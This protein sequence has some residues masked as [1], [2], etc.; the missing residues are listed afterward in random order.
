MPPT[1]TDTHAEPAEVEVVGPPTTVPRT[2]SRRP[3]TRGRRAERRPRTRP[4]RRTR[5]V[6]DDDV[7]GRRTSTTSCPAAG[8]R[9]ASR[10]PDGR[11]TTR[12]STATRSTP[13]T[14]ATPFR[15]DAALTPLIVA[16]GASSS[17]SWPT[18]RTRCSTRCAA[19]SRSATSMPSC[20]H[21]DHAARY[22]AA[23]EA[24]LVDAAGPE[25][26]RWAAARRRRGRRPAGRGPRQLATELVTPLRERMA[27][28]VADGDGE[29]RARQAGPR[30][31]RE[32]KTQRIDEHLD[33]LFRL[34]SAVG[35]FAALGRAG[36]GWVVD[37]AGP[38]SPDCEDNALAGAVTSGRRSHPVTSRPR[39]HRVPLHARSG[40][41]LAFR[42][43]RPPSDLPRRRGGRRISGRVI[44]ILVGVLFLVVVVLGRALARFYVDYLWHDGLGRADV[45]WGVIRAKASLFGMF[46]RAF[47]VLAGINLLIADRLSPRGSPPTSTRSSSA[48]TR[49]SG[50]ACAWCATAGPCCSPCS[51]P[52]RRRR[53]GSRGCCSATASRSASPTASSTPT[54]GS[55]SSSCRSS[56]SCSTGCSSR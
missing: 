46:F 40:R 27:R 10:E 49:S 30:L 15:R 6:D 12:R 47:V 35:A 43:V 21:G 22:V 38:P 5:R 34:P 13:P 20:R 28:S 14:P 9:R 32:W 8:G 31:Y 11:S 4:R 44:L 45:F 33:D 16:A 54:S 55:T 41:P 24:E 18:S 36:R 23:I 2:R 37:P 42:P 19:G 52:C 25:R 1:P 53:S 17:E 7:D 51:S 56:A 26:C 3:P 50:T 29:R 48:S 39:A